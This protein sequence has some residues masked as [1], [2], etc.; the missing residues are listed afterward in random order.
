M[1]KTSEVSCTSSQ[2]KSA[3]STC[4]PLAHVSSTL[5]QKPHSVKLACSCCEAE[6]RCSTL[7]G[8]TYA[9][10]KLKKTPPAGENRPAPPLAAGGGA[11]TL[12]SQIKAGAKLK[13]TPPPGERTP[14]PKLG[15]GG[16]ALSLRSQ[17][18]AVGRA[19]WGE[20]G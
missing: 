16:G 6:C 14:A 1:L 4:V 10:A 15:S 8:G 12:R 18:K 20:G 3:C 17:I 19:T 11:L 2:H 5:H 9:G 13:K 7:I